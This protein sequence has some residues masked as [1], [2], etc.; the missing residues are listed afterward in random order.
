M[1]G[2]ALRKLTGQ[3]HFGWGFPRFAEFPNALAVLA[4]ARVTLVET[5]A[6]AVRLIQSSAV[7]LESAR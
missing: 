6:N 7:Q 3:R 4:L 5:A 2:F 1:Q